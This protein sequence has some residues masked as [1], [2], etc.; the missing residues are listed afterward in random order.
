M[1]KN[2]CFMYLGIIFYGASKS[3]KSHFHIANQLNSSSTT[4]FCFGSRSKSFDARGLIFWKQTLPLCLKPIWHGLLEPDSFMGGVQ[5][6]LIQFK[7]YKLLFDLEILCMH[8]K[9]CPTSQN[10]K[11]NAKEFQKQPRI[12]FLK[13]FLKFFWYHKNVRHSAKIQHFER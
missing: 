4:E 3:E 12:E 2:H 1:K 11:R 7:G 9:L 6:A 13:K 10:Q 5:I 8:W